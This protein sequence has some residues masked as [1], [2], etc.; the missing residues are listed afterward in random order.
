MQRTDSKLA[1]ISELHYSNAYARNSGI[2]E[3]IEVALS[4]SEDPADFSMAFYEADGSQGL[5]VALDDSD[6]QVTYDAQT[7]EYVYVISADYYTLALTDPDG[8]G[9]GNYEAYA[10]VNT[11]TS[12]VVEF[13]DIGGGTTAIEAD[14]GLADGAI[15]ENVPVL[16]GPNST[17]TTIQFNQPNP[18]VLSY[19]TIGAGDS[20]IVCFVSGAMIDTPDGPRLIEDLVVGD[21]VNTLDHGPQPIR[22]H[23]E[24]TVSGRGVFAPIRVDG[25][26]F[27]G[28]VAL[29]V[30]PQHRILLQGWQAEMLMGED[31]VLA[32]A[33]H[34]LNDRTVVRAPRPEVTYHHIMFDAHQ[35]I[36]ANGVLC[37]SFYPGDAALRA[38]A[39][40][41]AD[42]LFALFPELAVANADYGPMARVELKAHEGRLFA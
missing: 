38:L 35:I 30:S 8:G 32:A 22:W 5:V 15:S 6:V 19:E 4:P 10:L 13:L 11:D 25:P 31:Q 16:V 37:E 24:R 14:G 2:S 9:S 40:D 34:L 39:P 27:G 42:E 21:L 18:D 17:T 1:R 23:G 36:T 3:F 7:D 33:T 29:Y 41:C 20:G 28:D 12:T 26:A